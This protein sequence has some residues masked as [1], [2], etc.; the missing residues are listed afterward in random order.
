MRNRRIFCRKLSLNA[1]RKWGPI[2]DD[3]SPFPGSTGKGVFGLPSAPRDLLA[4][5]RISIR[6]RKLPGFVPTVE[7]KRESNWGTLILLSLSFHYFR[8]PDIPRNSWK[9]RSSYSLDPQRSHK[10]L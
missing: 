4:G 7:E 1:W 9:P 3:R 8:L 10:R 5:S 2:R 6:D